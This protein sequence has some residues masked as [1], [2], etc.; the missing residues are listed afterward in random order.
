MLRTLRHELVEAFR[1][2]VP[3][4]LLDGTWKHYELRL[5]IGTE[6]MAPCPRCRLSFSRISLQLVNDGFPE[7]RPPGCSG[8]PV[9][10]PTS[11]G[12]SSS[13]STRERDQEP[14]SASPGAK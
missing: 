7:E 5:D 12:S 3:V 14:F 1:P 9:E 11:A 2:A 13:A 4:L 8:Q 6:N 10:G